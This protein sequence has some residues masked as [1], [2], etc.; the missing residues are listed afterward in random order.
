LRRLGD[1]IAVIVPYATFGNGIDLTH[2]D[3]ITDRYG[4]P[5]VIDAAASLGTLNEDGTGF[6]TGS[7]HPAV[8]SMHVTKTFAASEGGLIYCADKDVV[9]I[10]RTMGN[11]GFG[12]PRTAT[13]PGLNSKLSEIGALLALQKLKEFE[14]VVAHRAELAEIYRSELPGWGFQEMVGRRHAY[15]FMPVVLPDDCDVS[16]AEVIARLAAE[17][18]G[19]G[20]Y[21]SPHLAEQPYFRKLCGPSDLP[22]T[23]RIAARILS[24][25]IADDMTAEEA[26][27]VSALVRNSISAFA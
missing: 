21:F 6:G 24:L 12:E 14:D 3:R 1:D 22:V 7:R 15:Q 4:V 23:K 5:V 25:P 18:V 13:M 10:L 27:I 8:Y 16:R 26:S 17:R 20:N 19:A 11:F 9:R 2:Y